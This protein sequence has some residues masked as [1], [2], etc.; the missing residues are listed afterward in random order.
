MV[1]KKAAPAKK[2]SVKSPV[3]AAVKKKVAKGETYA[4]QV[5][6]LGVT[7]EEIGDLVVEQ[8]SVLLCCGA[9]M[10]KKAGAK[11]AAPVKKAAAKAK[12]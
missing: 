2:A 4:C 7:V 6:G 11:K 1:Q 12:K 10:K 9:P 3:K 8:D 5:C